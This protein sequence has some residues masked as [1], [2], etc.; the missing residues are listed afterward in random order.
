[1]RVYEPDGRRPFDLVTLVGGKWT[2]YR[3]CAEQLAD[4]VLGR[5]GKVRSRSTLDAPIGGAANL[6]PQNMAAQ[7]ALADRL[8][9]EHAL[10]PEIA[11]HLVRRYGSQASDVA[12]MVENGGQA[13]VDGCKDYL[14]G[15]IRWICANER[16]TRLSDI[17]LRRTLLPFE[18]ALSL[19]GLQ[20]LSQIA[21]TALGWDAERRAAEV[22]QTMRLLEN[23]YRLNLGA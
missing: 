21:A 3:A 1:L 12:E 4:V 6:P 23:R 16:V 11:E 14:V 19:T 9:R 22:E 15:E 18:N 8:A 13:A 2:T 7:R 10:A 5:L 17:A 20:S